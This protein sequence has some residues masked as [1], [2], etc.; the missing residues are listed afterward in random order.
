MW[1]KCLKLASRGKAEPQIC[2]PSSG[3]EKERS[4]LS[5]EHD[6]SQKA[7][8]EGDQLKVD[9]EKLSGAKG[10]RNLRIRD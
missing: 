4:E 9:L 5:G 1:K 7:Y 8:P 6:G 2:M 10:R 3:G